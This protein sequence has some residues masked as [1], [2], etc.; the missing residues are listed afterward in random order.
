MVSSSTPALPWPA[1]YPSL[2]RA[3]SLPS[4]LCPP[5]PLPPFPAGHYI[6]LGYGLPAPSC[7]TGH[8]GSRRTSLSPG[9]WLITGREARRLLLYSG[10][11]SESSALNMESVEPQSVSVDRLGVFG[12]YRHRYF[13]GLRADDGVIWERAAPDS[14]RPGFES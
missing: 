10:G 1:E 13:S 3:F 6:C 12:P 8:A 5:T 7:P 2:P 9:F 4:F 11:G 14:D